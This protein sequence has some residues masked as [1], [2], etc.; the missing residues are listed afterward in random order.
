MLGD[1]LTRD[2]ILAAKELPTEEIEVPEWGG[3]VLIR[4]LD[5]EGR[6]EFEAS[7]IVIRNNKGYPDTANT[8]AKLAARCIIDPDTREPMFTQSDV[9]ALGKLSGA[10]LDRVFTV[11][12]RLSGLSEEDQAELEGNSAAAPGGDS[13]SPSPGIS[14]APSGSFSPEPPAGS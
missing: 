2:A 13:F 12:S 4:G 10:A 6:D 3:T 14:A 11:A 1:Y 8:R 9:Y 5:G 7:M